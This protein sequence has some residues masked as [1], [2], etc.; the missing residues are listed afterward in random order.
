MKRVASCFPVVAVPR[1][2]PSPFVA[3]REPQKKKSEKSEKGNKDRM[4]GP[5]AF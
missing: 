5:K 1:V 4:Y 3:K 2:A